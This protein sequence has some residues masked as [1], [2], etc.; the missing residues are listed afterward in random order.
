MLYSN[1]RAAKLT[2]PMTDTPPKAKP[3]RPPLRVF[4]PMIAVGCLF[5]IYSVFWYLAAGEVRA[6]IEAF[7]ANPDRGDVN[8]GWSD[9]S[10]SGYPYRIAATFDAPVAAAPLAPEDWSWRAGSIEA[11]FL[12]YNLHHVVLR[13]GGEQVLQYRDVSGAAPTR[14]TIRATAGGAWASYVALPGA[15]IG[16]LAID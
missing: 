10:I 2:K 16:R 11:D 1:E 15:P 13:I 6:A 7:A 4:A 9:L 3:P 5:A 12:P 8:L 14:H